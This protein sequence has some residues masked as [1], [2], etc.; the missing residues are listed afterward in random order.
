MANGNLSIQGLTPRV[1]PV[2]AI[3]GVNAV[4]PGQNGQQRGNVPEG[5]RQQP[6]LRPE[7]FS[8]E[9]LIEIAEGFGGVLT[10]I[11]RGISI[12]IDTSTNRVITQI[13]D[14]ETQQVIRQVPPEELLAAAQ[15]IADVVG[16][17]ID[18]ER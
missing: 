4:L 11:N 17:I 13:V 15:R 5:E 9:E 16:L 18:E 1:D 8:N 12:E 2:S 14:Q 7:D 3:P 10:A 6:A